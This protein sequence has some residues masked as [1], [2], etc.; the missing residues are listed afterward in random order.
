MS[1]EKISTE[2]E[3]EGQNLLLA[4]TGP[5][6]SHLKT[7]GKACR[8]SAS[9]RGSTIGLLGH[10][11][12]VAMAERV[13]AD[14]IET[15]KQGVELND[16]EVSRIAD[17][18]K[19]TP[20]GHRRSRPSKGPVKL[21]TNRKSIV[22]K[23][24]VQQEYIANIQTHDVTFGIGPAGTGK[25]FLAVAAACSALLDNQVKKIVLTRPAVEAGEKLG[26]LPGG[27]Q[28]KVDPYLRP[29]Y[30][31]LGEMIDREKF[32]QLIQGGVIE[33]APLAFMRGRTI[34]N[35]F[36]ILDEA[37]NTTADQMKMFLTRLGPGSKAVITGDVTQI[38]L[39]HNQ[40]SGLADAL[41][42]L[43]NV[44][45]ISFN[46]FS[47]ADVVRHPMVQRIVRAYEARADSIAA[48]KLK[49]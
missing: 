25:S 21:G 13:I 16:R 18:A 3:I 35:S 46:F 36:I 6:V 48:G 19:N 4:L 40:R 11:E 7:V 32:E 27:L 41:G 12:G 37:Q 1:S 23:G 26:F 17:L 39:P 9:L 29:L 14:L 28:E 34:T 43:K 2:I 24:P 31:A 47:D 33:V 49:T 15:L 20:A 45:G 38:D 10:P 22:P 44:E 5:N 8:V 30:D 42:L